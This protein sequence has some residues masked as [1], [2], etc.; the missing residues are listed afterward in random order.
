M[1]KAANEI[2]GSNDKTSMGVQVPAAESARAPTPYRAF[3]CSI[4]KLTQ[5]PLKFSQ[6]LVEAGV[7]NA[8]CVSSRE[9]QGVHE[10][11]AT[12]AEP[13]QRHSRCGSVMSLNALESQQRIKTVSDLQT[14]DFVELFQYVNALRENRLRHK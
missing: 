3:I 11:Y 12:A 2:L 13:L 8:L 6:I 1:P 4:P 14:R 10:V 7:R 9:N 5:A